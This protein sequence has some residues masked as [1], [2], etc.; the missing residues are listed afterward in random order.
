[1]TQVKSILKVSEQG[2]SRSY[3][4]T[5]EEDRIRWRKGCHT[6]FVLS[7]PN[8]SAPAWPDGSICPREN[9]I[10]YGA[11]FVVATDD[12]ATELERQYEDLVSLPCI[13]H[14]TTTSNRELK[15]K[16]TSP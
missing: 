4:C 1:M 14:E 15:M 13:P 3:L 2:V 16:G 5:D 7:S 9:V 8:E 12:P 11:P 6:G 10:R